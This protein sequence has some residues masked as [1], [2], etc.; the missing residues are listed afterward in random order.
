MR[1]SISRVIGVANIEV[2]NA[3]RM[4]QSFNFV[5]DLS[6]LPNVLFNAFFVPNL[7]FNLII[8]NPKIWRTRYYHIKSIAG[9]RS[10]SRKNVPGHYAKLELRIRISERNPVQCSIILNEIFWLKRIIYVP[11]DV[12][13]GDRGQRFAFKRAFS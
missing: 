2:K 7:A 8:P 1:L 11:R 12:S 4:Q 13:G 3:F 6:E 10:Q 9:Q 5:E